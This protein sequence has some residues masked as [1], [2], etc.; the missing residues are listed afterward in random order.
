MSRPPAR[1]RT[2][3]LRRKTLALMLAGILAGSVLLLG[4]GCFSDRSIV[5]I[6]AELATCIVPLDAVARGDALVFVRSQTFL[7]QTVRVRAGGTVT[8]INCEAAGAEAHTST[9]DDGEWD[10]PL[11]QSGESFSHPFPEA[12]RFDYTCLPHPFMRGVVLVE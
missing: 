2:L 11:L 9:A 5:D 1:V 10:S 8:W 3:R 7:P 12:G 4:P 6:P